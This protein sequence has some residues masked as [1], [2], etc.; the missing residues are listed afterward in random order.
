MIC[1]RSQLYVPG[2]RTDRLA[3][4]TDRG[5]D[6]LI[7]D[8]EDSV[9]AGSKSDARRNV[10]RW[11]AG[12]ARIAIPIWVRI[13]AGDE[14]E[15]D[16][17]AL[18]GAPNLTGLVLAK[19]DSAADVEDAARQLTSA[20]SELR[21]APLIE[22]AAAVCAVG[23]VAAAPRVEFLHLG[24]IDLAA[25]LGA[26]PSRDGVELHYA[27]SALV[28]SSR[29]AH[30]GAPVAPV[31]AQLDDLE[32]FRVTTESLRRMG[33][34]GRA[35]IHPAQVTV[36]NAVFTPRPD[37]IRWARE[38]LEVVDANAHGAT[39]DVN[40]GMIDEAVLRRARALIAAADPLRAPQ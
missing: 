39:R 2:D 32:H 16:I 3:R 31:D 30:I 36:A 38:V 7:I 18:A 10:V 5:A 35:C 34:V 15:R 22:S 27:R 1:A 40:G 14:R 21:L 23:A 33:F 20:G 26:S 24:E 8:L 11:L 28:L 13:N 6:A 19:T 25:D 17:N 12:S 4:A 9:A 29:A 37:D